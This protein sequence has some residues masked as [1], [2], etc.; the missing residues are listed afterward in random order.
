M[1][2]TAEN[3]EH[4]LRDRQALLDRSA[5]T[6]LALADHLDDEIAALEAAQRLAREGAD[7]DFEQLLDDAE[8]GS[9]R[10]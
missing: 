2:S 1:T 8:R 6:Y 9:S 5:E 10:D 7:M 3:L 4:A